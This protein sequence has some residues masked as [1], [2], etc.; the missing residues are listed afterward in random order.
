MP[1]VKAAKRWQAASVGMQAD[2]GCQPLY[3]R[4]TRVNGPTPRRSIWA[5]EVRRPSAARERAPGYHAAGK[6]GCWQP[7]AKTVQRTI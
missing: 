5:A 1:S 2:I 7:L 3:G 4:P 6:T